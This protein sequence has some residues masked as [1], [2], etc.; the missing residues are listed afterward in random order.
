MLGGGVPHT[1]GGS[2]TKIR[3][4]I[5]GSVVEPHVVSLETVSVS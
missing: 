1:V 3:D 4:W 5:S 2:H